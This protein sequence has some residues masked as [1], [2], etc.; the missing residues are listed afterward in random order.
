MSDGY[1]AGAHSSGSLERMASGC[2]VFLP[3]PCGGG[4]KTYSRYTYLQCALGFG[5][6]MPTG[7]ICCLRHGHRD[8]Q[9]CR[10]IHS[11]AVQVPTRKFM[12][13]RDGGANVLVARRYMTDHCVEGTVPRFAQV[14]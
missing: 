3:P 13:R 7:Q 5:D 10:H 4:R 12:A 2:S 9:Y 1:F 6:I 14:L 11:Q 8:E